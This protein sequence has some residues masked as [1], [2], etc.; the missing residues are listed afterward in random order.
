MRSAQAVQDSAAKGSSYATGHAG[1][2]LRQ[3]MNRQYG[4]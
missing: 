2:I 1:G 4:T 3:G